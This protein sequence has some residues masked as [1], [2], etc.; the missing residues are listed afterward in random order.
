[1]QRHELF[2][3][4]FFVAACVQAAFALIIRFGRGPADEAPSG[5]GW[6]AQ[7][8]CA[9]ACLLLALLCLIF[10]TW[11]LISAVLVCAVFIMTVII[12]VISLFHAFKP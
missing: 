7:T 5:R 2:A 8:I 4:T 6:I 3:L 10:P 11:D 12:Q 1:M 9:S